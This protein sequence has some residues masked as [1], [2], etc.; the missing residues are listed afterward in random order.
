MVLARIWALFSAI[1]LLFVRKFC[2]FLLVVLNFA[3][4]M[5]Q[6]VIPRVWDRFSAIR[7]KVSRFFAGSLKV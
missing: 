1:C 6:M 4:R 5:L 7:P 2:C 3:S